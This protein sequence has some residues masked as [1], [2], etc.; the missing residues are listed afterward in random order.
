M[1]ISVYPACIRDP[2]LYVIPKA[3]NAILVKERC[4]CVPCC[5]PRWQCLLNTGGTDPGHSS[6]GID[7]VLQPKIVSSLSN[8][9]GPLSLLP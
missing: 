7:A 3:N 5:T 9:R 4:R 6:L 1:N 2:T 8:Y